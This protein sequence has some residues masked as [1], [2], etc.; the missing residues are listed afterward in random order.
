MPDSIRMFNRSKANR[1]RAE[2]GREWPWLARKLDRSVEVTK[3]YLSGKRDVDRPLAVTMADAFGVPVKELW[4]D[5]SD[6][7]AAGDSQVA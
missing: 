1:L 5:G 2:Q 6:R 3:D 4:T 7:N